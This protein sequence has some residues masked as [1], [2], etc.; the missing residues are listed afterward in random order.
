[1]KKGIVEEK[2]IKNF[3]IV[4]IGEPGVGKSCISDRYDI[5]TFNPNMKSG[6]ISTTFKIETVQVLGETNQAK[7]EIIDT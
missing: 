1:M 6:Y 7:L 2:K 4:M 3:K 5:F